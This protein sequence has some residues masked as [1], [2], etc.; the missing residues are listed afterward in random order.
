V[1][2]ERAQPT[3]KDFLLAMS[4]A[5]L[6]PRQLPAQQPAQQ[7][8]GQTRKVLMV[9]AH[10]D[11]EYAFAAT[12]YR[13][14]RELGWAADQVIVTNGEAGYR[15]AA[16]AEAVYGV[17][18]SEESDGR[19]HL[20][21]IRKEEAVRAGKILG[22]RRHYF[23]DQKD[24][25]FATDA[26]SADSSNWDRAHVLSAISELLARER[27]DAVFTLLP[28]AE[29]HGHHRAAT[30]LALEA[31]A[32]QPQDHRPLFFGVEPRRKSDATPR[33]AGLA[34][35]P[36]TATVN[37]DPV[38]VFDRM[39]SFGYKNALNYQIVVN[40]VIAE[41]KSQGLFQKDSSVHELEQFWLFGISGDG[42]AKRAGELATA[43][44]GVKGQTAAQ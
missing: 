7:P 19:A 36:L 27:Y 33:F 35:Q 22:I 1:P 29:T 16:L 26:A 9:V 32:R 4:G 10:P 23:L 28:T 30:L 3:R 18:L 13:M 38:F 8:M 34:S 5:A 31:L 6:L 39:A 25:G 14:V 12:T 40:W 43:L 2:A 44:C 21:A 11:D 24:S 20:P 15:Y 37:A 42:A 41:H 17:A